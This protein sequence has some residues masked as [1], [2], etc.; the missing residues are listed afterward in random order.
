LLLLRTGVALTK[1]EVIFTE[2]P[3]QKQYSSEKIK[4][5]RKD[6]WNFFKEQDRRRELDF[7]AVFPEM[8]DFFTL[9]KDANER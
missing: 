5:G 2:M 4:E 3:L 8:S 9:C 1:D 6:F 7:E